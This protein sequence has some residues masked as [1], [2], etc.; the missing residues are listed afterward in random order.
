MPPKVSVVAR[1]LP[2]FAN[3]AKIERHAQEIS[4]PIERLRYLRQATGTPPRSGRRW[5]PLASFVLAIVVAPLH[6]VS[7]ANVRRTLDLKHPL[8][9]PRKAASDILNVWLVDKTNEFEVYSNG[10]RVENQL[11][12]SAKPRWYSLISRGREAQF[13]PWRSQP[14]GIVFHTTESDQAPFEPN[15]NHALKHIGKELLLYVRN[16]RAYHFLIDRFGRVHRIVNESDTANH[17]GHS[18]WADPRWSYIDLNVSFLGVA[19]EARTEP[20]QP[21]VNG[22][23]IHAAKVLT[24]MLRSKYNLPAENCITHAQVSVN[25]SNMRIGWHTDLG[26]N[27]PFEDVGLPDNYERPSPVLTEFGFGY[28]ATYMQCTSPGI[29][30]GLALADERIRE[31]AAAQGM[32][33]AKYRKLLQKSYRNQ[34]EALR[35]QGAT[36]EN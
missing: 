34:L 31:A 8:Q 4:D 32:E 19:F 33:A 23:Q 15:Q 13:G 21:P 28:D 30:R 14:A 35:D 5:I 26:N 18:V 25:P 20:N 1:R 29:W 11:S 17:A 7:D 9:T 16:K 6:S 36:E 12:V 2:N 22:A 27:F 24:E 3:A 10:L